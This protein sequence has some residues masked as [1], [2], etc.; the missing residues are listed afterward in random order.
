MYAGLSTE[1]LRIFSMDSTG[2]LAYIAISGSIV[3]YVIV[4]LARRFGREA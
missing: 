1:V 3:V 2:S 4:G